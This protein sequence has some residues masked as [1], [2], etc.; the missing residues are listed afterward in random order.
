MQTR[1]FRERA[2]HL[3]RHVTK[4]PPDAMRLTCIRPCCSTSPG[5][6]KPVQV[7]SRRARCCNRRARG[8][9]R[10]HRGDADRLV[11][12]VLAVAPST[13][14][15]AAL[16]LELIHR[17]R[18]SSHLA[19][20]QDRC[21][22]SRPQLRSVW[23]T[24]R[25]RRSRRTAIQQSRSRRP[26]ATQVPAAQPI[27]ARN[28]RTS[29]SQPRRQPPATRFSN[30]ASDATAANRPR[31]R[32]SSMR[33]VATVA[34]SMPD[35]LAPRFTNAP[36]RRAQR[37]DF[38]QADSALPMA[39]AVTA[40]SR[41][42]RPCDAHRAARTRR[43]RTSLVLRKCRAAGTRDEFNRIESREPVYPRQALRDKTRGWV[44]TRI[45]DHRPAR[46][47]T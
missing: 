17:R 11:Q 25:L 43:P 10:G 16:A 1:S 8:S 3:R 26:V 37:R 19:Q 6:S 38:R 22:S 5:T 44:R 47:V 31:K 12:R 7:L 4:R 34:A 42:R 33:S 32:T 23:P 28:R 13:P 27:L 21:P 36:P 41:Y 40:A 39:G 9:S 35:P 20:E 29:R 30:D 15:A 45:H 46:C 2:R 14:D 24:W 18:P